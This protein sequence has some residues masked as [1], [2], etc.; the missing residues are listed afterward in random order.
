MA[1]PCGRLTLPTLSDDQLHQN[2]AL[3]RESSRQ[4][5][6]LFADKSQNFTTTS[7]SQVLLAKNCIPSA[8]QDWFA[9]HIYCSYLNHLIQFQLPAPSTTPEV[10]KFSMGTQ[11]Q[12]IRDNLSKFSRFLEHFSQAKWLGDLIA[13][14]FKKQKDSAMKILTHLQTGARVSLPQGQPTTMCNHCGQ[15][16]TKTSCFCDSCNHCVCGCGSHRD[17]V[18]VHGCVEQPLYTNGT[19]TCS[20]CRNPRR[21]FTSGGF[22][23]GC[24]RCCHGCRA[25]CPKGTSQATISPKTAYSLC[26]DLPSGSSSLETLEGLAKMSKAL[27]TAFRQDVAV[28]KAAE[29][30]GFESL[31]AIHKPSTGDGSYMFMFLHVSPCVVSHGKSWKVIGDGLE[32]RVYHHE[33][34]RSSCGFQNL[35]HVGPESR[36]QELEKKMDLLKDF[37]ESVNEVPQ[38]RRE[39]TENLRAPIFKM[40]FSSFLY[41]VFFLVVSSQNLKSLRFSGASFSFARGP[42]TTLNS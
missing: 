39:G 20:Y 34:S 28:R 16:A 21:S 11:S 24:L 6:L 1:Q 10:M 7:Q 17:S 29:K 32:P 33:L 31:T 25:P 13:P 35:H 14:E 37:A 12:G 4:L 18:C 26:E 42:S 3:A 27:A 30:A 9:H 40:P 38:V 5:T 23:G 8:F 15:T 19:R 36:N 41:V 2:Q 22:C